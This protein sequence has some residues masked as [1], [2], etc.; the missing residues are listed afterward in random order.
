MERVSLGE[1]LVDVDTQ[2]RAVARVQVA[3]TQFRT[4]GEDLAQGVG[5]AGEFLDTE[6]RQGQVEVHVG[7]MPDRRDIARSVEGSTNPECLR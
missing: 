3:M 2:A 1:L 6:V 4:T 5:D 7:G